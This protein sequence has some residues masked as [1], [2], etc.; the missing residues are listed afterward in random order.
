MCGFPLYALYNNIAHL[1]SHF[2]IDPN[3]LL[4]RHNNHDVPLS[5]IYLKHLWVC[6]IL[7]IL[8]KQVT[9]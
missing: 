5:I 2:V 4:C 1:C 9:K 6:Q 8:W 7:F 3:V